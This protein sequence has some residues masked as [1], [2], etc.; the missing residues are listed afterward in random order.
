MKRVLK[1]ISVVF[2]MLIT[3]YVSFMNFNITDIK[4]QAYDN[5]VNIEP[6]T[7]I[8]Y[9]KDGS[10]NIN[11]LYS[12]STDEV[13]SLMKELKIDN[14][15]QAYYVFE[16]LLSNG[17]ISKDL[18]VLTEN[19]K[20]VLDL[21]NEELLGLD[22]IYGKMNCRHI[23]DFYT[24]V[25]TKLGYDAYALPC[26][27]TT[28]G[29][30]YYSL[31]N[32]VITIINEKQTIYIDATNKIIFDKYDNYNYLT[33]QNYNYYAVPMAEYSSYDKNI[34][35]SHNTNNNI[36]YIN[37]LINDD[38][39]NISEN[40]INKEYENAQKII[41]KNKDKIETFVIRYQKNILDLLPEKSIYMTNTY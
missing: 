34:V 31:P 35:V 29:D 8:V 20:E 2:V 32:H 39:D 36:K 28:S 21:N 16:Y 19:E 12:E 4:A 33:D 40:N 30:E 26:Y 27:I 41:D 18:P 9:N 38:F 10:I 1:V 5:K 22:V 37:N 13:V 11:Y 3:F 23:T 7:P 24:K 6:I 15:V 25:L 17:Y 14:S